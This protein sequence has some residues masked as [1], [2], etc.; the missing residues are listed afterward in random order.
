MVV[1]NAGKIEEVGPTR[2][3]NNPQRDYTKKLIDAIPK[4][5]VTTIEQRLKI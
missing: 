1:M 3:T 5:D 4:G 2:F